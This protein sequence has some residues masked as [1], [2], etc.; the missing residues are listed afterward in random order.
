VQQSVRRKFSCVLF[1]WVIRHRIDGRFYR[2]FQRIYKLNVVII[3]R[4]LGAGK[5]KK[6][7]CGQCKLF[8]FFMGLEVT[9]KVCFCVDFEWHID[10]FR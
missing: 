8:A 3:E 1:C 5:P 6:K 2:F 7:T 10:Q 4:L 9:Q